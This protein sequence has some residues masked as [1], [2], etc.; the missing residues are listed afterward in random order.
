MSNITCQ[1]SNV[2]CQ[3][4]DIKCQCYWKAKPLVRA[5]LRSFPGH[6][7]LQQEL[8]SLWCSNKGPHT[9]IFQFSLSPMTQWSVTTIVSIV[10]MQLRA[11]H[12]GMLDDQRYKSI[13]R[14]GLGW[15][16][17]LL[18]M[19][20]VLWDH[21]FT[22]CWMWMRLGGRG[23]IRYDVGSSMKWDPI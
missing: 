17:V 22:A 1:T 16:S 14:E 3:M 4:S 13:T 8:S 7:W 10:S 20:V 12:T 18:K 9:P 19:V 15:V 21:H 23:G 11:T 2:K 5:Y 6:F